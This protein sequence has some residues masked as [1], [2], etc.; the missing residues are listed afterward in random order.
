MNGAW[1][2]LTPAPFEVDGEAMA[3][4]ADVEHARY[5]SP[6][7]EDLPGLDRERTARVALVID[8]APT[9]PVEW[10]QVATCNIGLC[11]LGAIVEAD[12]FEDAYLQALAAVRAWQPSSPVESR[13]DRLAREAALMYEWSSLYPEAAAGDVDDPDADLALA[14]LMLPPLDP[15]RRHTW[16][17]FAVGERDCGFCDQPVDGQLHVDARTWLVAVARP[18]A[19]SIMAKAALLHMTMN[20]RQAARIRESL[21]D[22]IKKFCDVITPDV[23]SPEVSR[24]ALLAATAAGI[25]LCRQAWHTQPSFDDGRRIFHLEHVVPV[26][27]IRERCLTADD[28]DELVAILSSVR[29]AWILK[30]ENRELDRLGLRTRRDDPDAAYR[31]AGI[32]LMTCHPSL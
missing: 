12:T 23:R 26:R 20:Q 30:T 5:L 4:V 7:G 3:I 14:Q 10:V 1:M 31:S 17:P 25:D 6:R 2:L 32:A 28:E 29:L 9:T 24:R 27:A 8:R 22:D 21:S 19:R 11:I 18:F 13:Q 16:M 15:S